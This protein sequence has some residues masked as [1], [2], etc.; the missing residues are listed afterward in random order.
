MARRVAVV[1]RA[2]PP[3]GDAGRSATCPTGRPRS[4]SPTTPTAP[5]ASPAC[6]RAT[7]IG[8]FASA[9]DALSALND[10]DD[11][12]YGLVAA[13]V[14]PHR[15]PR[16]HRGGSRACY[17][18]F[19]GKR[20]APNSVQP[21]WFIEGLA[22]YEESK[23]RSSS[24][25]TRSAI[26]DMYLRTPGPRRARRSTST[27]CRAARCFWPHGNAAYLYGSFFLKYI[28]D[29]YGDDKLAKISHEYGS[30][31]V[32]WGL[33][34][35]V[36]RAV[37][38]TYATL[39]Q[40]WMDDL[41]RRYGKNATRSSRA[42]CAKG[43]SSPTPARTTAS[44]TF[45]PTGR[46]WSGSNTTGRGW[47]AISPCRRGA[48]PTRRDPGWSSRARATSPSCPTG[49]RSWPSGRSPIAPSTGS[50]I[51]TVST[52]MKISRASRC[53]P[54]SRA[55]SARRT[56]TSRPT[57]RA[58]SSSS[59]AAPPPPRLDAASARRPPRDPLGRGA[60]GAG[61]RPALLPRR[62]AD[63]V[64]HLGRRVGTTTSGSTTSRRAG[65]GR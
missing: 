51:S 22:T 31:P 58:S 60:V 16:H 52:R 8:L 63:R 12:L 41:R 47:P 56:P 53:S 20:W 32:P 65:R 59:T 13:R 25:R 34:R 64:L 40:E 50:P 2:R 37:G 9:P 39:Y 17:N 33:N 1:R 48:V 28:G 44:P 27:R 14:H 62:Q 18:L 42:G 61:V 7:Q 6:C 35:A 46:A 55:A 5:T 19:A 43:R 15:P 36:F 54:A 4:S 57:G 38:K 24:G 10:H 30:Q 3:R 26:F 29:R 11:W 21:R 49:N 23:L 45:P